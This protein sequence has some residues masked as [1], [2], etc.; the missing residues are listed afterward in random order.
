MKNIKMN[1]KYEKLIQLYM[2]VDIV[3]LSV[4]KEILLFVTV[5]EENI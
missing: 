5:V 4:Q 2:D 3:C 1:L